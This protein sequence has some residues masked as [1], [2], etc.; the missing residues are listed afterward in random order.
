VDVLVVHAGCAQIGRSKQATGEPIPAAEVQDA[1][2]TVAALAEPMAE[3]GRGRILLVSGLIGRTF[4]RDLPDLIAGRRALLAYAEA[5]RFRVRA[6][7][8]SVTAVVPGDFALR[9]A[10]R[11]GHPSIV[12]MGPDRAAE[13]IFRGVRRGRSV[14]AIPCPAAVAMRILC[15][16][17]STLRDWM[18]NRVIPGA[19]PFG[20]EVEE[21]RLG[22]GAASG[23]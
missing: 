9:A 7:G 2:D 8:L 12:M 16:A 17:P 13:R 10:D 4:G 15:L 20:G 5:L 19:E 18:R 11:S 3:R 23:D 6:H 14:V 1:M 21:Q 22:T